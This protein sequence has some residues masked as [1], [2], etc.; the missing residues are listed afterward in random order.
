[1]S[2]KVKQP[3]S[4]DTMVRCEAIVNYMVKHKCSIRQCSEAVDIP[5]STVHNYI[6]T[7]IKNHYHKD[8]VRIKLILAFNLKYRRKPRSYWEGNRKNG[9]KHS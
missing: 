8:Y 3:T 5:K 4:K 6:H 7:H 2:K 9:V 1:M